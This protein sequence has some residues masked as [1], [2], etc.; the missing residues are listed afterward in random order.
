MS[1][2]YQCFVYLFTFPW[3]T[4]TRMTTILS[5]GF[6]IK[7]GKRE[8]PLP[9]VGDGDHQGEGPEQDPP[10]NNSLSRSQ[11]LPSVPHVEG[12]DS[13]IDRD[14][15]YDRDS[16]SQNPKVT[17]PDQQMTTSNDDLNLWECA[18]QKARET[19]PEVVKAYGKILSRISQGNSK[20]SNHANAGSTSPDW[21]QVSKLVE[22]G[23][24]EA[25]SLNT[26]RKLVGAVEFI[27]Q[28][29]KGLGDIAVQ[30]NPI[31][32]LAWG[33]VCTLLGVCDMSHSTI[34]LINMLTGLDVA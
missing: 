22:S 32:G 14:S 34:Q 7:S 19:N 24:K 31:A 26:T 10:N 21:R 6:G 23:L 18:Y 8:E 13:P 3:R 17:N 28:S 20:V 30:A 27:F 11:Q 25:E 29:L 1:Q 4:V 5:K 12:G 33:G 2:I 16:G 9:P 15:D